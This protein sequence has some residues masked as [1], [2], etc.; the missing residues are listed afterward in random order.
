MN[1]RKRRLQQGLSTFRLVPRGTFP[2][3]RLPI[4]HAQ[5]EQDV[6]E[7]PRPFIPNQR[8]PRNVT[9]QLLLFGRQIFLRNAFRGLTRVL[10]IR[11]RRDSVLRRLKTRLRP[12][13]RL[14]ARLEP[15][16]KTSPPIC[17]TVLL[18]YS[19]GQRKGRFA[20]EGICRV[21]LALSG[22]VT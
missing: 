2:T 13:K 15:F 18:A 6:K 20:G 4:F 3:N 21:V 19:G 16:R 11:L 8:L 9:K 5:L 12:L 1:T 22:V 14:L 10:C 17:H 7:D